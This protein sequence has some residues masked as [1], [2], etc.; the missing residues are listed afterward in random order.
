MSLLNGL[1]SFNNN[2]YSYAKRYNLCT[3]YSVTLQLT[4]VTNLQFLNVPCKAI[5]LYSDYSVYLRYVIGVI[6]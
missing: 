3:L 2:E 5:V 6:N 4:N 1:S